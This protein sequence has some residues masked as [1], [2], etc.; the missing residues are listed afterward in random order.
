MR[1]RRATPLLGF[2]GGIVGPVAGLLTYDDGQRIEKEI[3]DLKQAEEN[4]S[5]LMVQQTHVI[6]A[7]LEE[8][9]QHSARHDEELSKNKKQLRELEEVTNEICNYLP[10]LNYS[11]AVNRVMRASEASLDNYIRSV[12]HLLHVI[13]YARRGAMHP[14]LLTR[15][16]I[17]PVTR[18][19]Q[20]HCPKLMFPVVGPQVDMDELAKVSTTTIIYKK[21]LLNVLLDIPLWRRTEYIRTLSNTSGASD[22]KDI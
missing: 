16:Q 1:T 12:E 22:S 20:D 10:G 7:Q 21:G 9:H 15:Q 8:I 2:L 18:D 3:N 17:E 14:S 19:V 11:R 6:R 4:V 13:R 5:L